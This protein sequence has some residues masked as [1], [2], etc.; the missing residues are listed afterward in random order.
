MWVLRCGQP[1]QIIHLALDPK[2]LRIFAS[3]LSFI[4]QPV[5]CKHFNV[6]REKKGATPTHRNKLYSCPYKEMVGARGTRP[7]LEGT[8]YRALARDGGW[9]VES[10]YGQG[11]QHGVVCGQAAVG[12][13]VVPAAQVDRSSLCKCG[14]T[15]DGKRHF[16]ASQ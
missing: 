7:H 4:F 1:K 13:I 6:L 16:V 8:N 12:E 2:L 3:P 14:G 11:S 15:L 9:L 5:T 10:V